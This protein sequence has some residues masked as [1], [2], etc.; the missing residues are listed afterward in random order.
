[1]IS[2]TMCLYVRLL[3]FSPSSDKTFHSSMSLG[4]HKAVLDLIDQIGTLTV[5][6]PNER[7]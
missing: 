1:M 3:F 5:N 7:E 4:C 2:I 6:G